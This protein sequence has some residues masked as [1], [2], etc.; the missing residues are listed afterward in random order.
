MVIMMKLI[1]DE[2]GKIS[3]YHT[4]V[5]NLINCLW[6]GGLVFSVSVTVTARMMMALMIL[7][8]MMTVLTATASHKKGNDYKTVPY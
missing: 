4:L 2:D 7:T 8:T 3:S 1:T 6:K 5:N